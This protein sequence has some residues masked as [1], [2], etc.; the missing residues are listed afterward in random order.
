MPLIL[1]GLEL[2]FSSHF[3]LLCHHHIDI[4]KAF[5]QELQ[6]VDENILNQSGNGIVQPR[7]YGNKKFNLQ[8][9][10]SSLE[11]AINSL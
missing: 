4:R 3:F 7:L 8:Q 10:C 6:P 11:S 5:F 9:N 2:E 1:Y